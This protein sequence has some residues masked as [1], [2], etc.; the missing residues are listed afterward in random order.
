[1]NTTSA[2]AS[3]ALWSHNIT[4]HSIFDKVMSSYFNNLGGDIV[5]LTLPYFTTA[6][7]L[8]FGYY[9]TLVLST[10]LFGHI[11]KHLRSSTTAN[12][13]IAI[14]TYATY[15]DLVFAS[16]DNNIFIFFAVLLAIGITLGLATIVYINKRLHLSTVNVMVAA[17]STSWAV[18]SLMQFM[19]LLGAD[20]STDIIIFFIFSTMI[21]S[22]YTFFG[23]FMMFIYLF[24]LVVIF[25]TKLLRSTTVNIVVLSSSAA[26]LAAAYLPAA[27]VSTDTSTV[28]STLFFI[29]LCIF[30]G[31]IFVSLIKV[32]CSSAHDMVADDEEEEEDDTVFYDAVLEEV[33]EQVVVGDNAEPEPVLADD[34]AAD[35]DE[36]EHVDFGGAVANDIVVADEVVEVEDVQPLRRSSR[37]R[38]QTIFYCP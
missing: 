12:I 25:I 21:I 23:F 24:G 33:V 32:Y 8:M 14:A 31:F 27:N 10:R 7:A 35:Q 4:P 18:T 5:E 34:A 28:F 22:L 9:M 30:F 17:A 26:S 38:K 15:V 16:P 2:L 6:V 37:K 3:P 13:M 11:I 20:V 1:M 19:N 36:D 29:W